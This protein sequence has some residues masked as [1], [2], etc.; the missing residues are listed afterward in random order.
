MSMKKEIFDNICFFMEHF[1]VNDLSAEKK[2]YIEK[3]I[4][5]GKRNGK[6]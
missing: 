2:R 5:D 3:F 4:V 6:K 1:G